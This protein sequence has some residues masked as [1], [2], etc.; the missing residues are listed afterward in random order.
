MRG[1]KRS[2]HLA[3]SFDFVR[4]VRPHGNDELRAC[5]D[6]RGEK[7]DVGLVHCYDGVCFLVAWLEARGREGIFEAEGAADEEADVIWGPDVEEGGDGGGE[8]FAVLVDAV[9]GEVG[10]DIKVIGGLDALGGRDA[11]RV[12]WCCDA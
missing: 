1:E 7:G 6:P 9:L 12:S 2:R 5:E 11:V 4:F 3:D 8:A 10:A